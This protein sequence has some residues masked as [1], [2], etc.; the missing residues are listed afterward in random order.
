MHLMIAQPGIQL[1][2]SSSLGLCLLSF[3]CLTGVILTAKDKYT[4]VC[5][6]MGLES[7]ASEAKVAV[8]F[9]ASLGCIRRPVSE[10]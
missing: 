1:V 9:K 3:L 5:D 4:A 10:Y 7:S 6:G 8:K 2:A